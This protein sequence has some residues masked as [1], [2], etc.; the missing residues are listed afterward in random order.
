M[1]YNIKL[2]KFFLSYNLNKKLLSG[3]FQVYFFINQSFSAN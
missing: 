1:K 3:C 2:V